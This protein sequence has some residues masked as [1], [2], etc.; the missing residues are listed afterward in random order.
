MDLCGKTNAWEDYSVYWQQTDKKKTLKRIKF[1]DKRL[2][3]TL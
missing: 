3:A 1:D 2:F